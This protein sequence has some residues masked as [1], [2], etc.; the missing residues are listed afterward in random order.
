[1]PYKVR[2]YI[3]THTYIY[4]YIYKFLRRHIFILSVAKVKPKSLGPSCVIMFMNISCRLKVQGV[5]I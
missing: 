5:M 4:I 3:H 2:I 1:M